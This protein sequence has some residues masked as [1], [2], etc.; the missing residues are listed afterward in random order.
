MIARDDGGKHA[1]MP[2][3]DD[4][5]AKRTNGVGEIRKTERVGA[6][7]TGDDD[8][9]QDRKRDRQRLRYR[10]VKRVAN[11]ELSSLCV[12][13]HGRR[14]RGELVR[15]RASHCTSNARRRLVERNS[16]R[17]MVIHATSTPV[18]AVKQA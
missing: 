13:W 15:L 16:D 7:V 1:I 14:L 9:G 12:R 5:K 8:V 11:D 4:E 6:E 2:P 10:Q 3:V 17:R 18:G